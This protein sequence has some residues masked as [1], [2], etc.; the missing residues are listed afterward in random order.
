VLQ[1]AYLRILEGRAR[2]GGGSGF[3][4]WLFGVIRNVARE[5]RRRAL[6]EASRLVGD[7]P[8]DA[9]AGG[10]SPHDAAERRV[11]AARLRNA[12][13]RLPERQRDVLHLVFYQGLTVAEAAE[14]LGVGVGTART[15]YARAKDAMRKELEP[16]WS[17]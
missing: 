3:R 16:Q 17:E 13:D 4:T 12:L 14:V 10:A 2:F 5:H 15:H 6:R 9:P 11:L 7:V 8:P 1:D